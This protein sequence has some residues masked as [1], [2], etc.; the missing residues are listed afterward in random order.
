MYPEKFADMPDD[1]ACS[2]MYYDRSVGTWFPLQDDVIEY[3]GF[4]PVRIVGGS[5]VYFRNTFP[6]TAASTEV[7]DGINS[8][9][10]NKMVPFYFVNGCLQCCRTELSANP[11]VKY[12]DERWRGSYVYFYGPGRDLFFEN[13]EGREIDNSHKMAYW[14]TTWKNLLNNV[15]SRQESQYYSGKLYM[16]INGA[17]SWMGADTSEKGYFTE[18]Y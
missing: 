17:S 16:T 13:K 8:R 7:G 5:E 9:D 4:L 10:C 6:K 11:L 14:I 1:G 2:F 18:E 3:D 12:P 15:K